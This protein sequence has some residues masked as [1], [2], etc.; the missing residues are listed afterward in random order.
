MNTAML[1]EVTNTTMPLLHDI[2]QNA[3]KE[4]N[5]KIKTNRIGIY[6]L[7]TTNMMVI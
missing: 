5:R 3:G 4:R 1:G 2:Q 7:Q 6:R